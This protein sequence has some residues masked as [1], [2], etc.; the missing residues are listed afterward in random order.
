MQKLKSKSKISTI[1]LIL[2]F[3]ISTIL[4]AFPAA[5]A[6]ENP[7]KKTFA[8]IGAVPNP[9]GVNQEVLLHI[10]ITDYLATFTDGW[11]GLSVTIT[12]PDGVVTTIDNVRTDSTGGTGR[13]F[14][15]TKVG[16]YTLQTHF[17]EQVYDWVNPPAF[18]P[19]LTGPLTYLA[20]DSDTLDLVVQ[21]EAIE[22][23]PAHPLPTEYWIRPIDTQIRE[24]YTIAGNWL[25]EPANLYAPY[26]DGPETAHIL[27]AVPFTTGGLV[28]GDIGEVAFEAGDAYEGK[29]IGSIIFAGKLYYRDGSG[30]DRWQR[31]VCV[32]LHTGEELWRKTLLDNRTISFGQTMFWDNFEYH[33]VFDY[34]WVT[35][36]S[37]W[38]AFD[39]FNG[40][41]VYTL[42][43]VPSGSRMFGPKGEILV[44]TVNLAEGW[45]TLWNSTN[46][47]ELPAGT[48]GFAK[49]QWRPQGKTVDATS[50]YM[51]NKTIPTGLPGSVKITLEDRIIGSNI[52]PAEV[53][54]VATEIL[55]IWGIS[56]SPGHEGTL[57]F[58]TTWTA[59]GDVVM[60]HAAA[61]LEDG[62]F[63]LWAKETRSFYA[64]SIENGTNLWGPTESQYY[65][66][67]LEDFVP[68]SK[69]IAYGKL[70]SA[71][72]GGVAYAYD[73]K[74]GTRLW[75]YE[76][77]DP[78]QEFLHANNW[79][80]RI[81]FIT[82]GK[83]YLGHSEHS[84]IEPKPR[85]APFICL[86]V[87][88][89][90]EVFRVDGLLH[91]TRWGGRAIIGDSIIA[92]QDTYD[93]RVYA[94]GKGPTATTV[95]APLVA[96]PK[97]TGV[98]IR[99][100]VTDIS[101]GT[102]EYGVRAR[103]P[104]GV[105]AVSD[106][107]MGDWMLYVYKNFPIPTD[108]AGVTVTID[109]YAPDGT[110]NNLGTVVS[111]GTGMFKMMW[112]PDD[113]GEYTIIATF[114]GSKSYWPSYAE[115]ALSV[116]P[117]TP[118]G[119]PIT[120]EEQP[121]LITTEVAILIAVVVIAAVA[122]AAYWV[123]RR[124]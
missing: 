37:T 73:I 105:P 117:A 1:A 2:I 99:G 63:V 97:G 44:H 116:G 87:E 76:A 80:L 94:I 122:I 64:F 4:V 27:W 55:R 5:T 49:G 109:A 21:A 51:W 123:L 38:Y 103:F 75:S 112:T 107:D 41:L 47:P 53:G 22:Y 81:L 119:G 120:P 59:P 92:S 93:Q 30:S 18:D 95:E 7:T 39:P 19:T 71:S 54:V 16:I 65:L 113:E 56:T 124:R 121:P 88:T 77:S 118:T 40:D 67:A 72:V 24:W 10:G 14:T 111:D 61:S 33:G 34:L 43:N 50:G 104:N 86:D 26:N 74:N 57:L 58:N 12:D 84:G 48:A 8:Y 6:Q 114:M 69:H 106:E 29:W 70:F 20:S 115:T 9:A 82:D 45:M 89:G 32:D 36:G 96:I 17:P 101:P 11:E 110:Y 102:E 66:D 31:V 79:W 68:A 78:Y 3:T 42:T 62:V 35:V 23:Y 60:D 85:G 108:L 46:I 100:K 91:S 90:E 25:T 83:I 15:P 52:N 98:T 28:G 13:V